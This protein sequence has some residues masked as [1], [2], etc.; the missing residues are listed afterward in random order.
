MVIYGTINTITLHIQIAMKTHHVRY[1]VTIVLGVALMSGIAVYFFGST[2]FLPLRNKVMS[3]VAPSPRSG[4]A[5]V[6]VQFVPV[7]PEY[8]IELPKGSVGGRGA[9][10]RLANLRTCLQ[11]K[12]SE[13]ATIAGRDATK[14]ATFEESC[15]NTL[16]QLAVIRPQAAAAGCFF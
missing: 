12:K 1:L 14:A 3:P 11:N 13:L 7:N 5:E 16:T 9:C 6:A 15:G 10:E 4:E 8:P 2:L